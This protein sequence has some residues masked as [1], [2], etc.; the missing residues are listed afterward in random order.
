MQTRIQQAQA[1]TLAYN[2]KMV[3]AMLELWKREEYRKVK[4]FIRTAPDDMPRILRD[5]VANKLEGMP[6]TVFINYMMI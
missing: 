2:D 5:G 6:R 1:E 3:D 4:D